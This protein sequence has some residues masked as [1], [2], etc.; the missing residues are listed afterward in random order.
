MNKT[1]EPA[2][3]EQNTDIATGH[4][5]PAHGVAGLDPVEAI[6]KALRKAWQLGQTYWQQADSDFTSQHKKS[7]ETS[8]KFNTLVAN[9]AAT[10]ERL[11][12]ENAELKKTLTWL[13][14]QETLSQQ[15]AASQAREQ[16]LRE[17]LERIKNPD[18]WGEDGCWNSDSYPDEIADIN[19]SLPQDDTALRQWGA[20]LLR[21]MADEILR[22][23][24]Y[25]PAAGF[26]QGK[27]DELE[28]G[29]K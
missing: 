26:L 20:K 23:V 22:M 17:A 18:N 13:P 14:T 28:R 6:T 16:Q 11:V 7:D 27:A 12:H 25:D 9:T 21:E 1:T 10:V 29:E 19:L 5:D 4:P 3:H 8:A 24:D 15:L 2:A